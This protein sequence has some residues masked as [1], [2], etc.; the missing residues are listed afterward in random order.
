MAD[1]VKY[2]F[3]SFIL[4][5][6]LVGYL[7]PGLAFLALLDPSTAWD[8]VTSN[9]SWLEVIAVLLVAYAA[10]QVLAGAGYTLLR[11][12]HPSPVVE[13]ET[14]RGRR[15]KEFIY[16]STAYPDVFIQSNREETVHMMRI[17]LSVA[18]FFAGA[19][20][21]ILF[22]ID[23]TLGYETAGLLS[24]LFWIVC[25]IAGAL[26]YWNCFEGDDYFRKIEKA[27]VEAARMM[28]AAAARNA[29]GGAT[30]ADKP[31]RRR[32]RA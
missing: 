31:R 14:V 12:L 6:D 8:F 18:L 5:R 9:P 28:E 10:A 11:T 30:E 4:L 20:H 22:A 27:A 25:V 13:D 23:L 26:L 21:L 29:G 15:Y 1:I 24:L 2:L 3:K 17:G 7:I 16:Y 32:N 19:F